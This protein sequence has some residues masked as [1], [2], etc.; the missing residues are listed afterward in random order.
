MMN[1]R[2]RIIQP[3]T[4]VNDLEIMEGAP[5]YHKW[6]F[7]QVRPFIGNRVL[8]VGAGLGSYT[9]LLSDREAVLALDNDFSCFLHLARRFNHCPS[10]IPVVYDISGPLIT[11]VSMFRPDT[12]LA[13]NVLEH[14]EQDLS[15]LRKIRFYLQGHGRLVIVVPAYRFLYGTIDVAVGHVRRYGMKDLLAKL[16]Q[17][18]FRTIQA[19]RINSL[20]VPAWFVN[21]RI[22]R[23]TC[24]SR[25]Q[26]S[27]Y[28]RLVV[29]WLSRFEKVLPP[30]F[31][32][33]IMAVAEPK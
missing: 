1:A 13:I 7:D 14:I 29:P 25:P 5:N 6:I 30:P 4:T 10:V 8:E 17:A 11:H 28:D 23:R 16:D 18:G 2:T 22:L 24:Q 32:L 12:A 31:G 21:G 9:S 19:R 20:A 33:S 26:V 15:A 3:G 27:F